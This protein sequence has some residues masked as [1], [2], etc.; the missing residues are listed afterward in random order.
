MA[1]ECVVHD[2]NMQ[3]FWCTIFSKPKKSHHIWDYL[4]FINKKLFF[5]ILKK[6]QVEE[7]LASDT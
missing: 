7:T 2:K 1:C 6:T 3:T 5:K 4:S